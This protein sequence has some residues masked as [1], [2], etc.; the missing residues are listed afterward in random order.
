MMS[1]ISRIWDDDE[2]DLFK[3]AHCPYVHGI[4]WG[5][6]RDYYRAFDREQ[7]EQLMGRSTSDTDE[8]IYFA[9]TACTH[10]MI[11]AHITSLMGCDY[12]DVDYS[13]VTKQTHLQGSYPQ[14]Y[15]S[16]RCNQCFI[17]IT[18]IYDTGGG[19]WLGPLSR[20]TPGG[21]QVFNNLS[22][23]AGDNPLVIPISLNLSHPGNAM[24]LRG[25]QFKSQTIAPLPGHD[26][27][28]Y[29]IFFTPKYEDEEWR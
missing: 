14:H 1:E 9:H 24:I 18:G 7:C 6:P 19:F 25:N 17:I 3:F 21:V 27:Y 28:K 16:E 29:V 13:Y 8:M 22:G 2:M 4:G 15:K 26:V 5:P 23:D 10:R 12:L 20:G 11:I